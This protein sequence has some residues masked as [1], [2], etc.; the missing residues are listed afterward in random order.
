MLVMLAWESIETKCFFKVF[1]NPDGEPWIFACPP[2]QP[3]R[4]IAAC[5]G[6]IAAGVEP[7]Q[8]LQAV[9]VDLARYV[10]QGVAEEMDIAALPDGFRQNL[11]NRRLK[12]RMIVGDHQL[13]AV[14][15]AH[16][17]SAQELAPARAAFPIGEFHPQYL[18]ATVPVDA[19]GN[20]HGMA[21]NHSGLAYAL[22]AGI[23]DQVGEDF[24]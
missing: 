17:E 12:S 13:H 11:T 5:F 7:A 8:L 16:L 9:V 3:G 18:A 21:D 23:D 6:Q 10:V 4:Q 22:V 14:K 1:F 20:Q 19:D 24:V 2:R 15:P